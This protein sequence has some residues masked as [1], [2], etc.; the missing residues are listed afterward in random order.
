MNADSAFQIGASHAICQ[1]YSLAVNCGPRTESCF[2][3]KPYVILADGCSSSPDT[4]TGA[5]LLVKAAAQTLLEDDGRLRRDPG[6]LHLE[7]AR[8]AL[9][10]AQMLGLS[11]EAVD[12]TLLT[13][14]VEGDELIVGC[15]GDGVVCFQS[16]TDELDVYSISYPSGYPLYPAYAHQPERLH[17]LAESDR[18][19]KVVWRFHSA[20]VEEPLRLSGTSGGSQ[21]TEVFTVRALDYKYVTLFTD[22]INSFYSA[23]QT[24]TSRRV[25]AVQID[26]VLRGLVSFKNRRGAFVARRLKSFLKDCQARGWRHLDDLAMGAL[27]LGD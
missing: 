23:R 26:E 5:R 22:G 25:E 3:Q 19:G 16:A 11:V 17:A 10:W 7:A 1:D 18:S 4:D 21:R 27:D 20:S 14:Y 9:R 6:G 15:T 12:A 2:Q 8:R 24:E 13:A